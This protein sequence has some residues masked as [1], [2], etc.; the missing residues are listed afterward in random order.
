MPA[1]IPSA[2]IKATS[3]GLIG[4]FAA[5]IAAAVP[6]PTPHELALFRP[7]ATKVVVLLIGI[8]DADHGTSPT[9]YGVS[10][11]SILSQVHSFNPLVQVLCVTPLASGELWRPVGSGGPWGLNAVDTTIAS[12]NS[13]PLRLPAQPRGC[14]QRTSELNLG[15]GKRPITE[16]R[17]ELLVA[18]RR[19]DGIHPNGLGKPLMGTFAMTG[20]SVG[21]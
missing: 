3:N 10:V 2:A 18:L 4:G 14:P 7:V 13:R 16:R 6:T 12:L 21:P 11:A 20:I 17:Q 9:S 19:V 1:V 8:N 15:H 5:D